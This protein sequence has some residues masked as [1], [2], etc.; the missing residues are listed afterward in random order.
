MGY[1]TEFEGS[2]SLNKPLSKLQK[3]Y[4]DKFAGTRHMKRN[5]KLLENDLIL[6]LLNIDSVGTEGEYYVGST[7]EP[8]TT[9]EPKYHKYYTNDFKQKVMTLLCIQ[10]YYMS[11]ID[12]NIFFE[13]IEYMA[14]DIKTLD[15]ENDRN[16]DHL[17]FDYKD[18][19]SIIN[20]NLQPETQPGLWCQ[21]IPS[22]DGTKIEWGEGEKFYNYI[23]WLQYLISNFLIPWGYRLNGDVSFQ[24][25]D[26]DDNGIIVVTDNI[27]TV[28]NGSAL[29]DRN[30]Y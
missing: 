18:D 8:A 29:V 27:I 22:S 9:W 26:E 12:Q 20:H 16:L 17:Y 5:V 10:K 28:Q 30:R 21:W 24:G 3:I 11:D 25:E 15:F 2:F 6:K 19:E 23:E 4:L 13:I 14:N 7:L 1:T